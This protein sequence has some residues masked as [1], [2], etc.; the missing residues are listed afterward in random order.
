MPYMVSPKFGRDIR[1]IPTRASKIR[2][3]YGGI[4][5]RFS[6]SSLLGAA[7]A[8]GDGASDFRKKCFRAAWATKIAAQGRPRVACGP[9][10][11]ESVDGAF[12]TWPAQVPKKVVFPENE[13]LV[14][15]P[16]VVY[17]SIYTS[18]HAGGC[19]NSF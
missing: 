5:K 10:I 2:G 1:E 4:L 18:E 3:N 15:E 8:S 9:V 12:R 16:M 17:I 13:A 7:P 11:V 19:Q 14:L 6:N